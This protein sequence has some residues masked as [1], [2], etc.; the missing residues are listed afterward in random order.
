MAG[1]LAASGV[2]RRGSD[3]TDSTGSF[4]SLPTDEEGPSRRAHIA[5][6]SEPDVVADYDDT[7]F[8]AGTA[9]QIARENSIDLAAQAARHDLMGDSHESDE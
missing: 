2:V 9:E 7:D 1:I 6:L 5:M 4:A 8:L 3:S